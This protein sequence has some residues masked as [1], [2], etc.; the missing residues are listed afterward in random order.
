MRL[1]QTHFLLSYMLQR[2]APEVRIC[3]NSQL[4][5]NPLFSSLKTNFFFIV[6]DW[7]DSVCHSNQKKKQSHEMDALQD[8]LRE[9]LGSLAPLPVLSRFWTWSRAPELPGCPCFPKL[10]AA[11]RQSEV[12]SFCAVC[13]GRLWHGSHRCDHPCSSVFGPEL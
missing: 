9:G 1:D 8:A 7:K 5:C 4:Q 2:K 11:A 13:S 6:N 3:Y 10:A 12:A